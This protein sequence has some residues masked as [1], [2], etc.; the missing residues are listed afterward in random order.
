[1]SSSASQPKVDDKYAD[2]SLPNVEDMQVELEQLVQ[3]GVITPEQ[4]QAAL[5]NRSAMSDVQ[6][7]PAL[8]QAQLD[9][10]A[11]LQ[12]IGQGG[13]TAMD[14]ASLNEM[15][16]QEAARSRGAREAILQNAQARGAGGSGMEILAQLQNSQDSATRA[17]QSGLD[18]AGMSQQRALEALQAA[19]TS[20]GNIRGQDFNEAAQKAQAQD[21]ISKFNAQNQQQVNMANT[22]AN[23]SAQAMNLANKQSVADQN[24]G[25]RNQQEQY[26]KQLVQQNYDNELKKRGGQQGVQNFNSNADWNTSQ[27]AAQ[28]RNNNTQMIMQALPL[29]AMAFS[30]ERLKDDVEDFDASEFLDSLT[31]HKYNYK[32]PKH[33]EG[34]HAG[35]M[36]QDLEKSEIGSGMVTDTPEGKM[37]D[38]KKASMAALASLANI[39]DRLKKLEEGEE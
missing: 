13:M 28:A 17:N 24:V 34:K 4:A 15:Q 30:D 7:D 35:V 32:N 16:N 2:L 3:Q 22:T 36:A 33:G 31:P 9:A 29:V 8:K 26:N 25:L 6:T 12:D 10:L 20:A 18:I 14:R 19:G 27:S 23:N 11:S 39:N 1:M 5:V 21:A 38:T 37:V